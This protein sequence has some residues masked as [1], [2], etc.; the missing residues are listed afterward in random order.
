MKVNKLINELRKA[1]QTG[2][3]YMYVLKPLHP[4]KTGSQLVDVC[5]DV[6]NTG[7]VI[8]YEDK[9][10]CRCGMPLDDELLY[11]RAVYFCSGCYGKVSL[12]EECKK[13]LLD[14]LN[15]FVEDNK[16]YIYHDWYGSEPIMEYHKIQPDVEA[17]EYKYG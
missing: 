3:V 11:C 15:N 1:N 2:A 6:K 17:R 12:L 5:I 10:C 13:T 8:M 4:D 16:E 9:R 14:D 7:D